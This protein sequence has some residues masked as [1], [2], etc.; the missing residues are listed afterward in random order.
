MLTVINLIQFNK[1]VNFWLFSISLWEKNRRMIDTFHKS[2]GKWCHMIP[3]NSIPLYHLIN[4]VLPLV[5]NSLYKGL[6][7]RD[8][9]F[10]H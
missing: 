2:F 6:K 1:N 9:K 3:D 8:L 7:R 4:L 10:L 5:N